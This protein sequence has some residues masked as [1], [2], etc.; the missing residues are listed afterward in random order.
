MP[1]YDIVEHDFSEFCQLCPRDQRDLE[2]I[3]QKGHHG[4]GPLEQVAALLNFRWIIW[5]FWNRFV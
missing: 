3:K 1:N 4:F 5:I 2:E